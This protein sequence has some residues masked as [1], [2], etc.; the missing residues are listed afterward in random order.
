[1]TGTLVA[2]ILENRPLIVAVA[3]AVFATLF[4]TLPPRLNDNLTILLGSAV[5][6]IVIS[7]LEAVQN[8][9]VFRGFW[10]NNRGKRSRK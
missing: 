7:I 6:M 5:A 9:G 2:T 4:Q 1:M 8:E 10:G 3:G